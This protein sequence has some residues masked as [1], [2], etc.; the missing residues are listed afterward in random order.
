MIKLFDQYGTVMHD[1]SI[2]TLSALTQNRFPYT[3]IKIWNSILPLPKE[4]NE[5]E[6]NVRLKNWYH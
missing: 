1:Q 5:Q 6:T 2:T 3:R 4:K